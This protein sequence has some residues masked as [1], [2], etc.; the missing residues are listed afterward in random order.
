MVRL[1]FSAALPPPPTVTVTPVA[2]A[3]EGPVLTEPPLEDDGGDVPTVD[4]CFFAC[5][6]APDDIFAAPY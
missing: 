5:I 4:P 6:E 3:P 1:G 2:Q